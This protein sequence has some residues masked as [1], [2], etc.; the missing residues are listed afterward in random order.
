M[1]LIILH[2]GLTGFTS[3]IYGIKG[4]NYDWKTDDSFDSNKECLLD[5]SKFV[6]IIPSYCLCV[7]KIVHLFLILYTIASTKIQNKK[8]SKSNYRESKYQVRH[9]LLV[10][11]RVKNSNLNP[12]FQN[13]AHHKV[14]DEKSLNMG[15]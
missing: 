14:C 5:V 12:K 9:K 8:I 2:N 13:F 3:V 15:W 1:L 4:L 11:G 7:S 6:L 10:R